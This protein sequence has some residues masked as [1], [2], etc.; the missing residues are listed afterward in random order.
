MFSCHGKG[1]ANGAILL[2]IAADVDDYEFL[3][4]FSFMTNSLPFPAHPFPGYFLRCEFQ[5]T[6][7][8]TALSRYNSRTNQRDVFRCAV[9]C[10][11]HLL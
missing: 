1:A 7:S 6:Q 3:T 9:V 8:F 2:L 10:H 11:T 4:A 5:V